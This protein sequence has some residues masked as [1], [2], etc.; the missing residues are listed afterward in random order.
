MIT[1]PEKVM[2]PDSGITKGELAEYYALVAPI[3]VPP[4]GRTDQLLENVVEP[5][6]P[7]VA[8]GFG[9]PFLQPEMRFDHK[10]CHGFLLPAPHSSSGQFCFDDKIANGHQ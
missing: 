9:D 10:A 3:M 6:V 7:E 1:H 2:F 4:V 8:A 5:L